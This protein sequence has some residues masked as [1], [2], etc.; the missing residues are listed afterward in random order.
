MSDKVIVK[1]N[2]AQLL[3]MQRTLAP[4]MNASLPAEFNELADKILDNYGAIQDA[5]ALLNGDE[6]TEVD[7]EQWPA[8][9]ENF[10]AIARAAKP[11]AK[12]SEIYEF[13]KLVVG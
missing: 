3:V 7:V 6:E 10:R 12:L 5:I 1:A 13:E 9:K 11:N 2:L 8:A 4:A